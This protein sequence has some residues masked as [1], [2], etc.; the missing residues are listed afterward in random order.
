VRTA[1]HVVDPVTLGSIEYAIEHLHVHLLLVLGHDGCGAVK[2]TISGGEAS[3]NIKALLTRIK[4]AVDKVRA[5]GVAE[6]ELLSAAVRE[7]VR[8]QMQKSLF[9]SEVLA[10]FVYQQK[11]T[12]AG[13]VYHLQSGQVEM[14]VTNLAVE[15][16]GPNKNTGKEAE[17]HRTAEASADRH[18][19]QALPSGSKAH[20]NSQAKV[21]ESN[22]APGRAIGGNEKEPHAQVP[23]PPSFEKSVRIAYEKKLDVMMK[24]TMLMRDEHDRCATDDC[25]KISPGETVKMDSPL[26]LTV[27]G[28]PQLRVRYK[29]KPYFILAEA[30]AIEVIAN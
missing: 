18:E 2:A 16:S 26:V 23:K 30:D 6:S 10:D 25:R 29:G 8:Y 22:K 24:K 27:M 28:R 7:N 11:L 3:P 20:E 9:E 19:A 4:P 5:E 1:G 17:A 15:R 13:G 14:V 12:V 21:Q